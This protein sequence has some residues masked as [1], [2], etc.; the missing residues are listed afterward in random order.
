MQLFN[1]P[2]SH[3]LSKKNKYLLVAASFKDKNDQP[4]RE[5]IGRLNDSENKNLL[6]TY[7]FIYTQSNTEYKSL[8]AISQI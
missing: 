1:H 8:L 5:I 2:F 3:F 4:T 6:Q 7:T